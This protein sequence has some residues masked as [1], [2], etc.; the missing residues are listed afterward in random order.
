LALVYIGH[1]FGIGLYWFFLALVYVDPFL[2][3]VH[4]GSFWHWLTLVLF[5]IG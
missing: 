2:A 4:I 3:L 1:F 5:G